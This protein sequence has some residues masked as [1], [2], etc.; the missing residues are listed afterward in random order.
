MIENRLCRE[1]RYKQREYIEPGP[2]KEFYDNYNLKTNIIERTIKEKEKD[3]NHCSYTWDEPF[4]KIPGKN[5]RNILEIIF[6]G[7]KFEIDPDDV[8]EDVRFNHR[9]NFTTE[10]LFS[11]KDKSEHGTIRVKE[12]LTTN[13]Y[14]YTLYEFG[15][16]LKKE[17][18]S[19]LKFEFYDKELTFY[20][21]YNGRI[22]LK[23]NKEYELYCMSDEDTNELAGKIYKFIDEAKKFVKNLTIKK[24]VKDKSIKIV[25]MQN[26]KNKVTDNNFE[27][28]FVSEI[29]NISISLIQKNDEFM[30]IWLN[31]LSLASLTSTY[32]YKNVTLRLRDYQIDN[33]IK[34]SRYPIVLS[35]LSDKSNNEDFYNLDIEI[36][37]I[38][39]S[40]YFTQID[41]IY[42]LLSSADLRL[43]FKFIEK[44]IDYIN[45]VKKIFTPKISDTNSKSFNKIIQEIDE[46]E[47]LS[48]NNLELDESLLILKQLVIPDIKICFSL[49][50]ENIDIFLSNSSFFFIKPIIEELGLKIL[51]VDSVMFNF[52][53][54]M[55]KDVYN[56][57]NKFLSDLGQFYINQLISELVKS[58]GGISSIT[59]IQLVE[60][61]NKNIMDNMRMER[62][63][64]K[65][66]RN[67]K[68]TNKLKEF[69][70]NI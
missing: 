66:V 18:N 3:F 16:Y 11:S 42:I 44:V 33:F 31:Q 38:D 30:Y 65:L 9:S 17:G 63:Q 5:N 49:N 19:E 61:L 8:H 28:M 52:V 29:E 35:P 7:M 27:F 50:F 4:M 62:S 15:L 26:P 43:E 51:N 45:M 53:M 70:I 1:I 57:T 48:Q 68:K 34:N 20:R 69:V 12:G 14:Y 37:D 54:F 22:I 55:K 2:I 13:D 40:K 64:V 59:S 47:F 10:D 21:K 36:T 56:S 6:F 25:A 41:Q 24:F 67:N 39:Y 60:N 58:L 46:C 32:V 23:R